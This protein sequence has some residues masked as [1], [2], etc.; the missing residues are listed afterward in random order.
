MICYKLESSIE[1]IIV[2]NQFLN[3]MFTRKFQRAIEEKNG[4]TV[5]LKDDKL[6]LYNSKTNTYQY[7]NTDEK[8]YVELADYRDKIYRDGLSKLEDIFS[9]FI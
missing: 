4:W 5:T 8:I 2:K 3:N 6:V 7:L 1:S 9:R